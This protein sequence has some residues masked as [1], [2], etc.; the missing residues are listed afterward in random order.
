VGF[1]TSG[2]LVLYAPYN[3]QGDWATTTA[4][5]LHDTVRDASTKNLYFCMVVHTSGTF[6][7]DLAASKW[8]LA[9]NVADVETAKTAAETAETN[10]ETAQTAAELAET[11]AETAETGAVTAKTAAETAKTAAETAKTAAETA[12]TAAETAETGAETAETGAVTAKTASE[13]A[14]T[15]S[16]TAKTAS[17]TAKTASETA[18]TGAETAK[19]GAETAKTGAETAKTGAETAETGAV[20]AK[21]GAETAKTGAETAKTG[22]ET[23][24]TNA[25][26]AKVAAQAAQTAAELAA[27]TFEDI[28]L[29]AKASDPTVDNDGDALTTGDLY[30]NTTSDEMKVWN[31][32]TWLVAAMSAASVLVLSGGAMTGA[33]TT[34]STFDGR[35]VATDGTKL[36]GIET[37]ATADQ[38]GAEI[39]TA[40]EA[41]ANAFTD[42]KN[43]KLS[44]IATSANNYTHPNHSGDVVSAAD[45]ATTIQAGAVDIAMLSATGTASGT[46]F[47]RGDNT[48]VV[49]TDTDTVYTHPTGAGNKHIP[50]GGASGNVLTYSSSGTATWNAPAAGG[51][52]GEFLRTSIAISTDDTALANESTTVNNSNIGILA[53]ALNTNTTGQDNVAIG[54]N[55]LT[56][57]NADGNTG[58]GKAVL[59]ENSSGTYCTGL[60][61]LANLY[62]TSGS[63]NLGLG[64][65]SLWGHPTSKL[66]G[67][68]N[69]GIG[70]QTGYAL[71]TGQY[72]FLGGY[73]AG[74]NMTYHDNCVM[75]GKSAG[76]TFVSDNATIIG[77]E[78]CSTGGAFS[79]SGTTVVGYRAGYRLGGGDN[80]TLI[81]YQAGQNIQYNDGNVC[82]GHS[83]GGGNVDHSNKLHIANNST[84]SLIEGDF[85]AKTVNIN[86][87][88]SVNGTAVGGGATSIDGL[89]DGVVTNSNIGLGNNVFTA[90]LSG[91][92]NTAVGDGALRIVAGGSGNTAFGNTALR[93]LVSGAGN[94]ACGYWSG[95]YA[96][97]GYNTSLGYESLRGANGFSGS[98]NIGIG[99]QT[100]YALSTG[101][102]NV[103]IGHQAGNAQTTASENNALGNQSQLRNV[104]GFGNNS[105]GAKTLI[106]GTGYSYD[107]CSA[108]GHQALMNNKGDDNTAF[109]YAAL[110]S[111]NVGTK[112]IGIGYGAGDAITTGSN[113]TIIGDYAG[114]T[115]LADTVA[116]YAGTTERLKV[117]STGLT[118]NGAAVGGGGGAMEFVSQTTVSS[119][120]ASV[121]FTSLNSSSYDRYV[122]HVEADMQ[123]SSHLMLRMSS[124]N[125]TS[126]DSSSNYYTEGQQN[127]SEMGQTGVGQGYIAYSS[128]D[129]HHATLTMIPSSGV[130]LVNSYAQRP[131]SPTHN[132]CATL[133]IDHATQTTFNAIQILNTSGWNITSGVFTLYGIKDS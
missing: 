14:K 99:Y 18:K 38:T 42:T 36:D 70:Y 35:D 112:N 61:Y 5:A 82:L 15:A 65:Y 118:V 6:A 19:T 105:F 71:S 17:E 81:G 85:S 33:I 79:S 44:G 58:V 120:T 97:G 23:A 7:T 78:A 63:H 111:V 106:G 43:T 109:G 80:N 129:T 50:S 72:N 103:L 131:A 2:D 41:E 101:Q 84:E 55:T 122:L 126:Y 68:Y 73:Q 133:A 130:I 30:F 1:D 37:S 113:N 13:T 51:G 12:K 45:G 67:S 48:W 52:I 21:T 20:T 96:T 9:I 3:W 128:G 66:T 56:T 22:A 108:F 11:N 4:Y 92:E 89:S 28:Y 29:G 47:L 39:K 24:E 102:Y 59:N 124:N 125:G 77:S 16:E 53:G 114:T 115:A 62:N 100:G 57:S 32:S 91:Y 75:I 74:Y 76:K 10:A 60:G 86:G 95:F 107:H 31:G 49:P 104:D 87:S 110:N 69:I 25:N 46:T 127:G 64:A 98:Y 93:K 117:D 83:A 94:T 123:T 40:Y 121:A 27:D 119:S 88:L 8:S 132:S 26:T 34:S 54:V 90:T 116:I